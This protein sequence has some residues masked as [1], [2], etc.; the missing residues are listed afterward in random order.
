MGILYPD[1]TPR[2]AAR[3]PHIN[4]QH[5]GETLDGRRPRHEATELLQRLS[6]QLAC[7]S[8]DVVLISYEDFIQEKR[9]ASI[10]HT[11]RSLFGRQ[12]FA[13]EAVLAVKPQ[14]E[15]L[16]SL[17][18]HRM[19]MLRERRLFSDFAK[20]FH[21]SG[22]F[23]YGKL[24]EPW[25]AACS[26]RVRAVPIRDTRS[27]EPLVRRML[28]E[29]GLIDRVGPLLMAGDLTRV[30]N[31][32]PGPVAVEV[33]RR[34]RL[35]R[36]HARL[37]TQPREMMRA[38]ERLALDCGF[39]QVPFKGVQP[40]LRAHMSHLFQNTND[41]FARALW[42]QTWSAVMMPEPACPVS[43]IGSQPIGLEM[44]ALIDDIIHDVCRQFAIVPFRPWTSVPVDV[45][46]NAGEWL[47][48]S[49]R[50]SK[51]RVI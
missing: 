38:V 24:I 6:G 31:R 8:A 45:L 37:Q 48:Q 34:L 19:Q 20:A 5:L 16:N 15:H 44:Q 33:S 42:G 17:Y 35:M 25:L 1:L 12:G 2:S 22:R 30:E 29:A 27:A 7:T 49:L 14:S 40:D 47:G 43:E 23:A 36:V 41:R 10:S 21:Q 28:V 32:S 46:I 11:L 50:I 51:W 26:G 18:T 4:H 3:H 13:M 9:A 39:D